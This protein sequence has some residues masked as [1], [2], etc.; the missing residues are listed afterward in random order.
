[1]KLRIR[2]A[3][4]R[5]GWSQRDL[6]EKVGVAP[7]TFHGYES[8]KHDPKSE[9]LLQIAELCGVTVD[10]LLG[11]DEEDARTGLANF[12]R[13]ALA[14]AERYDGLDDF[15]RQL[16]DS[17]AEHE[18]RRISE[19]SGEAAP[20][21]IQ[22]P[23]AMKTIP[24]FAASFAAGP[25]EPDFGNMFEQYQVPEEERADFAIR[26][27][28]DSMEPWL[29]DGQIALGRHGVPSDG[30]VAAVWVDGNYYVKQWSR[31]NYRNLYLRSLNRERADLDRTVWA[32]GENDV[33]CIGIINL[34]ERPPM[35][36]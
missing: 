21:L 12:S 11:R 34:P 33:R 19:Q 16:L 1:M 32:S 6:A 22:Q 8:G 27:H 14:L 23:R 30:D 4:E 36:F 10:Y 9:L 35:D 25:G 20:R 18:A 24:L 2:E 3:R 15:G 31:D 7:N 17:V 26:V 29:H 5:L 28:G 13:E